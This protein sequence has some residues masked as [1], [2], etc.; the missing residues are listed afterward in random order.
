MSARLAE[1]QEE[2]DKTSRELDQ[3]KSENSINVDEIESLRQVRIKVNINSEYYG[4][5]R[6]HIKIQEFGNDHQELANMKEGS[7]SG[8]DALRAELK[9]TKD[10]LEAEIASKSK[11]N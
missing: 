8:E 3:Q 9:S 6:N 4:I 5:V 11:V 7:A 1:L 10:Q 2:V